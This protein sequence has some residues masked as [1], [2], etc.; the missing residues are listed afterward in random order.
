M[1]IEQKIK[2]IKEILSRNGYKLDRW[3]NMVKTCGKHIQRFKFK[4]ITVRIERKGNYTGAQ[5]RNMSYN[6]PIYYK[7]IIVQNNQIATLKSIM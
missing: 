4:K 5:W 6:K 1:K 3:G 2:L 7:N